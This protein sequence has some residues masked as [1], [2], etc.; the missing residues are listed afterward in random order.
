MVAMPW[1]GRR[2]GENRL[3]SV[4][5]SRASIWVTFALPSVLS[6]PIAT[7]ALAQ[8]VIREP[9]P[10]PA[11][12]R[13]PV[14]NHDTTAS[15]KNP[16]LL[17]WQ[18]AAELRW[19]SAYLEESARMPWQ[20]HAFAFGFPIDFLG[21]GTAIRFDT[22]SPPRGSLLPNTQYLTWAT[23]IR[24]SDIS[25][26]GFSYQH[27]YADALWMDGLSSF[28]LGWTLRPFNVFGLGIAGRALNSPTNDFGGE[29]SP[30]WDIGLSFRPLG[31]DT[32]EVGLEASYALP[33][34]SP[35]TMS[36]RGVLGLKIPGFGR[37][38]GDLLVGDVDERAAQRAWMASLG[39]VIDM[40]DVSGGGVEY[41]M[42]TMAGS[43]LGPDAKWHAASNLFMDVAVRGARESRGVERPHVALKIQLSEV[44]S[45]REHVRLLR[46]LWAVAEREPAIEA[47]ILDLDAA[48]ADS[49]ART[50]EVRDAV[51]Y[52]RARGK[53]VICHLGDASASALLVCAGA[54]RVLMHPAGM[55]RFAGFSST[56]LYLKGLLDK[57]GIRADFVR[58]GPHK[59]APE[60]FMR[61]GPTE[62]ARADRIR[63]MK[64]IEAQWI[65]EVA[66]GRRLDAAAVAETLARGPMVSS[67]A[68]IARFVDR[69]AYPDQIDE[70]LRELIG[71]RLSV[72]E[73]V[74][75]RYPRTFGAVP[76]LALVHVDGDMV[77]GKSQSLPLFGLR[78]AGA[79]TL[80]STLER[81]REDPTVGA[82]VIRIDSPGGSLMAADTLWRSLQLLEHKKPVVVSMGGVAASGGYYI[83]SVAGRIFA[84]PGSV[85]GSI[86]IFYGK[87]DVAQL[88][89][90]IGISTDTAKTTPHADAESLFR[91]YTDE[92]REG[93]MQKISQYYQMFLSRVAEGRHMD[94][95]AVDQVGQ[96]KVFSGREALGLGLVDELGGLRQAIAYARMK[97]GLPDD[98]PI[99]EL[100]EL[101]TTLL[102]RVLGVEGLHGEGAQAVPLP[103][104]V[105][106]LV[107]GV[108]PM[109]VH[110]ADRPLAR[111]DWI[112]DLP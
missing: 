6:G 51:A 99:I 103:P 83:A 95:D 81:L 104:A 79:A 102:G 54:D 35:E 39:V 100:P 67:E 13:D 40:N 64:E 112:V 3:S 68:Q 82:V 45:T 1:N 63:L 41:G 94:L 32:L 47:V 96:G 105:L 56:Q 8:Q 4:A 85:T 75:P 14:S 65:G 37:V 46:R 34:Y 15:V 16:A 80:S 60:Q 43:G 31:T 2:A 17:A 20:G 87:A 111:M 50:Q 55:T 57:L 9:S 26:L 71:E 70:H 21:L 30:T 97:A 86:G 38:R 98:A 23:G 33:R 53:R 77:E 49:T 18:R 7:S 27:T 101:E 88:L 92:E 109:L 19:S 106:E 62:V 5:M 44:P 90:K 22:I 36:T 72:V 52:L 59:S 10:L 12:G 73:D 78:M 25:A 93:L 84:N 69:V 108:G 42:G 58:I 74:A 24:I 28:G 11:F 89:T 29:L 66:R 91:P 76:S 107:R 61:E 48:P 110:E